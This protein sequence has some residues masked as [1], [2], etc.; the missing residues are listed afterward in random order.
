MPIYEVTLHYSGSKTIKVRA[1]DWKNL[2]PI[3]QWR[4]QELMRIL[5][6]ILTSKKK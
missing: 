6:K 2:H 5:L 1:P 4:N 3:K